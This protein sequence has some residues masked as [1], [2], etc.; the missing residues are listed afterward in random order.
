MSESFVSSHL[1]IK[2]F[3]RYIN[4]SAWS[5]AGHFSKALSKGPRTTT[6]IWNLH[7]DAH[8]FDMQPSHTSS[9][10]R[11][12][13]FSSNTAH[14]SLVFFWIS[15]MHFHGAYFSNYDIWLKDPKHYFP[16]ALSV[17]SFIGQD[18]LNSDIGN[19]FQGIH[20]TS[21]LFQLWRAS[22]IISCTHLKY[23][24]CISLIGTITTLTASYFHMHISCSTLSPLYIKFKS[25]SI[26]H[27]SLFFGLS[28]TSWA[29]HQI[30]ISLPL[31]RLLDSGIDPAVLPSP[32]SLLYTHLIEIILPRFSVTP[33]IDFSF[34]LPKGVSILPSHP[35]FLNPSTGRVFPTQIAAHHF[36]IGIVF[37]TTSLLTLPY[38]YHPNNINTIGVTTSVRNS[39][40]AHLSIALAIQGSLSITFAHHIYSI[41]MYPYMASDYPTVLCSFTHH[42]WIGGFLIIGS[43]AHASIFI[44]GDYS[45]LSPP[46]ICRARYIQSILNHRDVIIGHL[47]W[48]T[49]ALGLHSFSLYIH[50]DTLQAFRRPEDIFHDN[51]IILKPVF[52]TLLWE[53]K[54]SRLLTFD[55]KIL[56]KK[57]YH[58]AQE[59]GTADFLIHHIHAFTIHLPLLILSKGILYSRSSRLVSDKLEL[60]FRYPCDGPGRG[61]TCQISPFDHIYLATFWMYNTLSV[62]LFH[63]FWK[64]ESDVWG[65]YNT[66]NQSI[67]H[68]TSGDFSLNSTTIN[69]WLTNFLWSQAA[70][71]IQSYATSISGYGFIFISAHFRWAFSLMFLYS[72]RGYWQELIESILWAHHKLKIMPH[73][74]PRALS[75]SQGRAVGFIHYTLGGVG[76][77]WAFFI[78]RMVVLN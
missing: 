9:V 38:H 2:L 41:P 58:L 1:Q 70:Q 4:S 61:G 17:W 16:S 72:G 60:G 47:I 21:G 14:L 69:G 24:S 42:M 22:G 33:L 57:V 19:Y 39:S 77:T 30:H 36:Y 28:S 18:I 65:I 3:F 51:S 67:T 35:K 6:W 20:I 34:A 75:I 25:L 76:C 62:V 46:S 15:G 71:V 40:H 52:A 55:I 11:R 73:I 13:V 53:L 50:N 7:S 74:Q 45:R 26:H 12:K 8:D 78:S 64:M 54:N 43:G 63:Y 23:A 49:L 68:I 44:I 27:L 5:K 59:L 32:Q 56:D 31:T 10:I 29:G 66:T 48:V 37:I